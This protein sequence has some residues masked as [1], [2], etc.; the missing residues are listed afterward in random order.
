MHSERISILARKYLHGQCSPEEE[1]AL[2]E[3]YDACA[4]HEDPVALLSAPERN[5]L[6]ARMLANTRRR[7]AAAKKRRRTLLYGL[8]GAAAAVVLALL[9]WRHPQPGA[10][11]LPPQAPGE[12]VV[13]NGTKGIHKQ[14]LPDSSIVWLS[15]LSQ[16]EYSQEF[17]GRYRRVRLTGEA[18]FQVAAD[19]ERPFV[20]QSNGI[21]TRVLGTSFRI[22]SFN[23]KPT[24]V[25]VATGKVA[26]KILGNDRSEMVLMAD[27]RITY[28]EGDKVLRR[29]TGDNTG[30]S[31]SMWQKAS[32]SFDNVPVSQVVKVL[33]KQFEVHIALKDRSINQY[34]LK[35]DFSQQNLPDILEMMEASLNI[36]YEM[37]GDSIIF[38]KATIR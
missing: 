9:I 32:L 24:E 7:I 3:W 11:A 8:T 25:S 21:E 5:A 34:L 4:E 15:P 12:V 38:S 17:P 20:I 16:L 1:R 13:A 37:R 19:P 29:N 30:P 10:P 33:N 36:T 31:M 27:Q 14:L 18:F 35:A 22:K 2:F 6:K 23:D 26:V 28:H